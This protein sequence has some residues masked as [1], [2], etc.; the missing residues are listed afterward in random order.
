MTKPDKPYPEFP[1]TPCDN[2]MWRKIVKGKPYTFGSW[3]SDPTGE[4]AIQAWL[5]RKDAIYAGLDHHRV[6][7]LQPGSG[8]TLRQLFMDYLTLRSHDVLSYKLA[9]DSFRDYRQNLT[10]FEQVIGAMVV[11]AELKPNH[12]A[13]YRKT[14][15]DRELGP[16]AIKRILACI[17]APFNHAIK[18]AWIPPIQF[19][20]AFEAPA[21]DSDSVN[22]YRTRK[23]IEDRTEIVLDRKQVRR[24]LRGAT[25]EWRAMILLILNTAANPAEIAR[26]KWDEIN[27]TTGRLS[28]RRSKKGKRQEAY[29]W[30]RTRVALK[31]MYQ[32]GAAH[33]YIF[34]W[35]D[36]RLWVDSIPVVKD[37]K[38]KKS[39]RWNFITRDFRPIA[40]AA[41]LPNVTPYTLRRTARMLAMNCRDDNSSRRMMGQ[42]LWG[43]DNTYVRQPFPLKRLKRVAAAI[44]RRLFKPKVVL[45]A[46]GTPQ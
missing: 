43:Q 9:P 1:L 44:Q 32:P 20:A 16:H 31:R 15:D 45:A 23:G 24:L 13:I 42:S 29:L 22:Q 28:R 41:G 10:D 35:P 27:W 34:V 3:R 14:L 4:A 38:V 11:A 12:F 33:E 25:P 46:G 21:T 7:A 30:K 40:D 17:K 26:F 8:M 6:P 37:Q 39:K 18:Q 2:G 36:G 5:E 19:G